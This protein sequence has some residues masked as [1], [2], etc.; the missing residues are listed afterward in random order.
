MR[1]NCPDDRT[2]RCDQALLVD[3]KENGD[4]PHFFLSKLVSLLSHQP[5]VAAISR[6]SD[7]LG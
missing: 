1:C 2:I 3:C 4:C 7:L 5:I 6:T